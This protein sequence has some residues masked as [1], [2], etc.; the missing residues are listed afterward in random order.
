MLR[1]RT[2]IYA[3]LLQQVSNALYSYQT[4]SDK[5]IARTKQLEAL[6]KL[7]EFTRALLHYSSETNYTDVL[8]SEQSLLSAQVN[9]SNDIL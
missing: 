1:R 5:K 9:S 6:Q 4:T 8:T 3:L 2:S 7:V